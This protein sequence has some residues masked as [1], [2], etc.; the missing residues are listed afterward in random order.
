MIKNYY[1]PIPRL[2]KRKSKLQKKPSA[3]KREHPALHNMNFLDFLTLLHAIFALLDPDPDYEY[4]SGST[5]LIE[6]G[7]STV[8][9]NLI[10]GVLDPLLFP[11]SPFPD[12]VT[13]LFAVPSTSKKVRSIQS[14]YKALRL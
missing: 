12:P 9:Y 13:V 3:L 7:H 4:R 14:M 8:P 6:S 2:P 11:A 10:S 1:L 5:D